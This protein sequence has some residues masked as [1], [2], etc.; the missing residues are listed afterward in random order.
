[1]GLLVPIVMV[2][3]FVAIVVWNY[4]RAQQHRQELAAYALA[5]G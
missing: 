3:A 2:G 1:M 4:R 5:S